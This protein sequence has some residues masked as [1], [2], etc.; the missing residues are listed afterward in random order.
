M[1]YFNPIPTTLEEL[2]NLY[3]EL[4][5]KHHPDCGGVTEAMQ[6]VNAEYDALFPKLKNVHKTKDGETYT[7]AK[8]NSETA[9][10][11]KQ[12]IKELM[13]MEGIIIEIIGCFIWVTGNTK[14]YKEQLKSLNFQWHSKKCAWYLKPENYKKRSQKD[15]SL[16]EIRTMYGTSGTMNSNGTIKIGV[17]VTA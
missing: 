5:F 8:E 13:K 11:Y 10:Q 2:K 3:R 12:I 15:F 9:D 16:D 4:A 17:S 6:A 7:T 14:P 1:K